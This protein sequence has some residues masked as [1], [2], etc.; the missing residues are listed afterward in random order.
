MGRV[1]LAYL[2]E[3][4]L[5]GYFRK[6]E[7]HKLTDVTVTDLE[8]LRAILGE[9]R[10]NGYSITVDQL[11]YGITALAVPVKDNAGRVVA[12]VNTSGY[13]PRLKPDDLLEQR[14]AEMQVAAARISTLLMRYP[15]LLHSLAPH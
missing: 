5:G 1:L 4:E 8:T 2:P 7:P 15:A 14:L 6:L 11:D 9:V 3:E 12:A 13:S 10:T